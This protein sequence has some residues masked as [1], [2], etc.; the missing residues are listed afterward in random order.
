M[1]TQLQP[2]QDT[3]TR[4]RLLETALELI[5]QSNY[6]SVGVNDICKQ[7]GVTKGGF[8]HYFDSKAT[9]FC[10]ASNYYWDSLKKDLDAVLSPINSP[11][12]QLENMI[13]LILI[14]KC[15]TS[16]DKSP[17]CPFFS[18]GLQSG[19]SDTTV[20][21]SLAAMSEKGTRYNLAL[22]RTL[23]A[24]GY[25]EGQDDAEQTARLM[26]QY[27]QGASSFARVNRCCLDTIR[28]DIPA[29]LYR[30][31]GLK[32]EFW[33]ATRATWPPAIPNKPA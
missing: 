26:S 24:G 31:L 2:L 17:G 8:Y 18:A 29:A 22:V 32:R 7:A 16:A 25:L 6:S 33:F 20:N 9:L 27:L 1:T 10:E 13:N 28:R 5:W 21:D 11:L 4:T 19:C 15:G 14:V 3:D 23:Q 30:L 12:E